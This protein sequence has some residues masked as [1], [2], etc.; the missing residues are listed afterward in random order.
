M[1][2]NIT[3]N[4]EL[5]TVPSSCTLSQAIQLWGLTP[6]SFAVALNGEFIHR[7]FY[8]TTI[9][10]TNDCIEIVTAMQGG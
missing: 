10:N 3:L 5:I 2:V 4:N 8:E 1:P 7:E 6:H 9:L